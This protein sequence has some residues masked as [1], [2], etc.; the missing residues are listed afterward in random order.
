M[1]GLHAMREPKQWADA[2]SVVFDTAQADRGAM[3]IVLSAASAL[4]GL[5]RQIQDSLGLDGPVVLAG[6]LLLHQP[7][8][9][10]AV[11]ERV[12]SRCIRLGEPPVEGAVRLAA[13]LLQQ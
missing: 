12:G 11:R 2:A 3:D 1:S 7:R 13:E 5:V 6:G 4:A 10:A 9:E 8:L